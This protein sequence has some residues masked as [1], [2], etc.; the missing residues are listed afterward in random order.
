MEF[1][2]IGDIWEVE[3]IARGRS[4]RDLPRLKKVHGAGQLAKDERNCSR[5]IILRVSP[6]R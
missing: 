1:E 5:P 4:I 2:I 6:V 3:S